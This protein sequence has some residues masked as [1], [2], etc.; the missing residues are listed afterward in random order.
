MYAAIFISCTI[1]IK[2]SFYSFL[3]PQLVQEDP[4]LAEKQW[5]ENQIDAYALPGYIPYGILHAEDQDCGYLYPLARYLLHTP[6][7]HSLTVN[8]VDDF[9]DMTLILP[10]PND[11]QIQHW[12]R[13]HYPE[14]L[15]NSVIVP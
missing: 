2:G 13:T 1:A 6:N 9:E 15:G 11:P 8:N 12:V 3:S 5:M 14:Q 10:D 4:W 7:V